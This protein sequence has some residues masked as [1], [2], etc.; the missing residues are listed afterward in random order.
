MH[1]WTVAKHR[2]ATMQAAGRG[3]WDSGEKELGGE[4]LARVD[5]PLRPIHATIDWKSMPRGTSRRGAGESN[6]A[7]SVGASASSQI[8]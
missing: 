5:G 1:K 8:R 4:R 3:L 6:G 2:V 7:L